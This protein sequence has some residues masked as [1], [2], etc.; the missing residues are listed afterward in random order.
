MES[1]LRTLSDRNAIFKYADD[2]NL[3]VPEHTDVMLADEFANIQEWACCNKMIINY[4]KTKEIVFHRP[5]P[6]K[7]SVFFDHIEDIAQVSDAKFLGV[8][9]SDN[10]S[11]DKHLHAV[12]TSCSRRFYLMKILRDG[13]MPVS[14]LNMFFSSLIIGRV[15]YC[16]SA[17]GGFLNAEQV[18]RIN[19]L[20]KRAKRYGFTSY[21]YDF[22]GLLEHVDFE[23]FSNMQ[24][25][26]HCLH[27]FLPPTRV[28]NC[29]LRT[30]GH[31]YALPKC[32]YAFYR[33]SFMPRCLFNFL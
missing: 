30:R 31:N 21:I 7:F 22:E 13:G 28:D 29:N 3:F 27:H 10:L 12:L 33:R 19:A 18:G 23:M 4:S 8:L 20:F 15:L 14:C 5:H 2:T 1:D 11:F 26:N 16:L 24:R 25:Q 17:W 9:L 32:I 6:S